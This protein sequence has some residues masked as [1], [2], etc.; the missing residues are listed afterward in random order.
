[1]LVFTVLLTAVFLSA[2]ATSTGDAPA[3]ASGPVDYDLTGTWSFTNKITAPECG[4]NKVEKSEI[5]IVQKGNM[6]TFKTK[7]GEWSANAAGR[8]IPVAK[9]QAGKVTIYGYTLNVSLDANTI[10]STRINWIWDGGVCGGSSMN[11]YKRK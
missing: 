7:T 2:C 10:E 3:K 6:V 8:T 5:E 1:L 4:G 9:S 11:T